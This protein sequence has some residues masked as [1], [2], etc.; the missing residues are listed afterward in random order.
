MSRSERNRRRT[1]VVVDKDTEV[2]VAN[3]TH[4]AYSFESPNHDF[5]LNFDEFGEDDYLTYGQLRVLKKQ[6]ENFELLIT[7]VTTPGVELYDVIQ[8]IHLTKQYNDYLKYVEGLV[9]D[10]MNSIDYLDVV[11]LEDFVE[12]ADE[13]EFASALDSKIRTPLIETSVALY[14]QGELNDRYKIID[15]QNTR[16][17]SEAEDFWRDI[18]ASIEQLPIIM[19]GFVANGRGR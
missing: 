19:K 4:D 7:E 14:K 17:K 9:E 15:I 2:I 3:L 13:D 12:E 5:S 11:A 10:E 18:D 6:L 16:P 1:R 8:G